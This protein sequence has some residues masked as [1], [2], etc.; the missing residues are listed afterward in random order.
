MKSKRPT[1][2]SVEPIALGI[3][4]D[5]PFFEIGEGRRQ[6]GVSAIFLDQMDCTSRNRHDI[7][8]CLGLGD[9]H[10]RLSLKLNAEHMTH[11]VDVYVDHCLQSIAAY[12][13]SK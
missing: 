12:Q 8:L 2:R 10:T 1:D 6:D 4:E 11:A 9:S 13:P 7:E 5:F 3:V